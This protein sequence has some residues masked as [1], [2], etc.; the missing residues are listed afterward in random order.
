MKE[1][2]ISLNNS[3][4]REDYNLLNHLIDSSDSVD[5]TRLDGA[6][7]TKRITQEEYIEL[8]HKLMKKGEWVEE[9]LTNTAKKLEAQVEEL[10]IDPVTKLFKHNLLERKLSNLIKELNLELFSEQRRQPHLFAVMVI[11]ADLD[12]LK[13]WNTYGH[14]VGNKALQT[15]ANSLKE[16]T[17]DN[18][19]VFRLGDKSDEIVITLR[20]ENDLPDDKLKEIFK[21]VQNAVN[22]KYLE[23]DNVKLPVTAA[24]GYVVLKRGESRTNEEILHDADIIQTAD[25]AP[26]IK[27]QRIDKATIDLNK[28]N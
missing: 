24:T 21:N 28:S 25:K 15:I 10:E 14:S 7:A 26:E 1:G 18:D 4:M 17:R 22:S 5:G 3:E 23:I 27:K 11:V 13:T 6:L 8:A 16:I 9:G 19:Y 12:N 20:I 2:Q